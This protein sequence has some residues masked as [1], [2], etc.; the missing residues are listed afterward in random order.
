MRPYTL[1]MVQ[2]LR[3]GDRATHVEFSNGTFLPRLILLMKQHL[4]STTKLT[5]TISEY[6][7][8]KI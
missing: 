2:A 4:I 1:H 6:G 7:D 3:A 5:V 8:S